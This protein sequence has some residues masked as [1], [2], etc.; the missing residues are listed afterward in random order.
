MEHT[1]HPV[2]ARRPAKNPLSFLVPDACK[3]SLRLHLRLASCRNL[4]MREARRSVEE[5]G[6]TLPQ[7]DV[8][9]ELGRAKDRGFTF[10]ELSRLL[11][12][13]AGNLTGIVDR[14][15]A[16]GS[17]R[18]AKDKRDRRI[19]R[20]VLTKRGWR[21]LEEVTPLHARDI[22]DSLTI[23]STEQ[24]NEIGHQLG[25]LCESLRKRPRPMNGDAAAAAVA[26]DAKDLP[27][28]RTASQLPRQR[29]RAN[30]RMLRLSD[31]EA[32]GH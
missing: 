8:L 21:L 28:Q 10:A 29:R 27:R 25:R 32:L 11:L 5:H 14:L 4:L 3:V 9:A 24:Q 15:E 7:F 13:T 12:V 18:R 19:V 30:L 31:D 16:D 2:R 17:V 20:I 22:H 6:L 23:L 1:N 26:E